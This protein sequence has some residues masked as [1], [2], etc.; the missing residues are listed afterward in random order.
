MQL[1]ILNGPCGVGKSTVARILHE[2]MPLSFLL[3]VD[4]QMHF[5]SHYRDLR[6]ERWA[7]TK[8]VG[9]AIVRACFR[10]GRDVILEKMIYDPGTLDSYRAVAD[11]LGADVREF[12]L[13][14]SKETVLAR[15]HNRGFRDESLL[16][17]EKCE[18]FWQEIERLKPLRPEAVVIE[19]DD[20]TLDEAASRVRAH[21]SRPL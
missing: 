7:L 16:T 3:D 9:Q 15:A 21:L 17:P 18:R 10:E 11:E 14:A 4:A 1:I 13:T 12:I 19:T 20:L 2:Q 8:A 6:E 5:I